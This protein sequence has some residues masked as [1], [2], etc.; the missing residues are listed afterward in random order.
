MPS[1]GILSFVNHLIV[2]ILAGLGHVTTE[3]V[4]PLDRKHTS[5]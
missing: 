1:F 2:A 4:S 3:W 5:D